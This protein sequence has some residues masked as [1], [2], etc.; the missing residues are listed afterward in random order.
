M[1]EYFKDYQTIEQIELL[2]YHKLG[3]HK[4]EALGWEYQLK[5]ARENTEEELQTAVEILS[6]YFK[7]VRIN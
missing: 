3:V 5:N 4:W 1:G 7:Q 2:P 6:P